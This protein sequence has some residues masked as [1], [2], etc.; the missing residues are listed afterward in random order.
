[1]GQ[2]RCYLLDGAGA[3]R[4][5]ATVAG[6]DDASAL[7]AARRLL[8]EKPEYDGFDLWQ[9]NRRVHVEARALS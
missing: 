4:G 2:Y 6:T 3:I 7:A 5:V 9:H 8:E 1:M